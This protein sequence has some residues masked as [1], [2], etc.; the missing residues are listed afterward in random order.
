MRLLFF[1]ARPILALSFIRYSA[2]FP[3]ETSRS[4]PLLPGAILYKHLRG[5]ATGSSSIRETWTDA[6]EQ[7]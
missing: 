3:A 4:L 6:T 2:C 7:A 5:V 1:Q